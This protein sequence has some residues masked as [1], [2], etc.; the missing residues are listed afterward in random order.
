MVEVVHRAGVYETVCRLPRGQVSPR[1]EA[2]IFSFV[3]PSVF[4]EHLDGAAFGLLLIMGC[5]EVTTFLF[6]Y[7]SINALASLQVDFVIFFSTVSF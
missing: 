4:R 2:A 6:V 3:R 7:D 5:V 1:T